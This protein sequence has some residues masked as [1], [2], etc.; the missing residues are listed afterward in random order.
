[1]CRGRRRL[2]AALALSAMLGLPTRPVGAAPPPTNAKANVV[3]G[4]QHPA[5][6]PGSG[7]GSGSR[8]APGSGSSR[9]LV[10]VPLPSYFT[11]EL[12]ADGSVLADGA[13]LGARAELG[14]AA[15]EA[16]SRGEFRRGRAV[17]RC[18]TL[19]AGVGRARGRARTGGF[20][21]RAASRAK[22]A[23]RAE[24]ARAC[25][26]RPGG[27]RATTPGG[28]G[29][30]SLEGELE[31]GSLHA[32][33]AT[34]LAIVFAFL[35]G[36]AGAAQAAI[37]GA[38]GRRVGSVQAAAFGT[39]IAATILVLLAVMLGRGGGIVAAIHQPRGSGRSASS[40][41]PSCSR[42]RSRRRSS[43]RSPRSRC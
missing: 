2:V 41:R 28:C 34:R 9:A 6:V 24:R 20:C 30:G 3:L 11:V 22:R 12:L 32:V 42:S 23:V 33:T 18:G 38:L 5:S 16:V 7:S 27:E 21:L 39:V 35:A 1:M 43:E 4:P 15:R 36:L 26:A 13:R 31:P 19:R 17:R 40:G 10:R 8:P 25:R 37:A 29:S 14:S